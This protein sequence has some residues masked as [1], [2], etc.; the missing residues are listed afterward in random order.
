MMYIRADCQVITGYVTDAKNGMPIE[1]VSI[2]VVD[3]PL[4]AITDAN[5]N[6]KIDLSSAPKQSVLKITMISY[7]S[8]TFAVEEIRSKGN[9][10][11][12]L[13]Q[14]PK[15]LNEVVVKPSGKTRKLGTTSFIRFGN[16]CGWP[17]NSEGNYNELGSEIDLGKQ[18]VLVK[19][20][21]IHVQ[22]QSFDS[23][24]VRLHIRSIA[25]K[26]PSTE[27]L[28]KNVFLTIKK[29]SGWLD[30]DLKTQNII[31][32]GEV[33]LS[34]ELLKVY[35][36]NKNRAMKI[37]KLM[38]NGYV[39]FNCAKRGILFSHLGVNGKWK[40]SEQVSPSFYLTVE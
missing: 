10:T 4:S 12:H 21:H 19:S 8:Q 27:L 35:G 32:N 5:G 18:S 23:V 1:Y 31:L 14:T 16:W 22:R 2:G 25:N 40:R 33:A 17:P 39:L 20:V 34:L 30:F 38:Q 26:V 3:T 28:T 29:E 6:F 36:L 9:L 7:Q 24:K 11:V 37:N 15:V 13:S